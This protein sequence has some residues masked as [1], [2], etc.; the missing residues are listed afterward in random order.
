MKRIAQ[1]AA[2]VVAAALFL[3]HPT[4]A[5]AHCLGTN[6][7]KPVAHQSGAAG[8]ASHSGPRSP[9][10]PTVREHRES[11]RAVIVGLW[12]VTF[13]SGGQV[14]DV[15]FDAWHSDG[16]ETLN[17]VSPISHNVCPGVWAQTAPRTFQLK[18][19][20]LSFDE[21]G[22]FIGTAVLKE[23]NIVSHDGNTFTGTFT[24][25]FFDLADTSLFVGAGEVT[26]ERVTLE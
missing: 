20:V 15:G 7:L 5:S 6:Q 12:K 25:E 16:T 23:T 18:H 17:D 21:A 22:T 9:F 8:A 26:G 13:T 3:V 1:G 4:N 10:E 24:I 19:M 11:E 14:T 2:A